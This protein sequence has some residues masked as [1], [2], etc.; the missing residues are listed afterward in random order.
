MDRKKHNTGKI[1]AKPENPFRVPEG[2]FGDLQV[3]V[4]D[5]IRKEQ[6]TTVPGTN[7][8]PTPGAHDQS[9]HGKG[10]MISMR[11]YIT[12]AAS[13]SGIA[14][15]VYILLQT[16]IGS[17]LNEQAI[18]DLEMLEK[19]GI[20]QDDY[21]IGTTY[22]EDPGDGYDQWE[23]DAMRYLSSNEVDLIYLI[24]SNENQNE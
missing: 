5:R 18:Y 17:R 3:Q 24:D 13:I 7:A 8:E 14:L 6:E 21:I 1:P 11:P 20:I 2:Y 15:V 22:E 12:L 9:R 19:T 23:E 10:R 16:V 4:M